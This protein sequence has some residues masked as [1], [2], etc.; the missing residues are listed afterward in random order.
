MSEP[1]LLKYRDVVLRDRIPTDIQDHRRWLTTETAWLDWDAPWE[2][3]EPLANNRYLEKMEKQL[4]QPLPAIRSTLEICHADGAHVGMVNAYYINDNKDKL[5]VGITLRESRYWGKGL[6]TLAFSLWLAYQFKA[7]GRQ[8]IYCETWSGNTRMKKLA[9]KCQ[10]TECKR[11]KDVREVRGQWYDA[12]T[13]VLTPEVFFSL[14]PD[15][16]VELDF[17][18]F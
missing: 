16:E 13:F 14:H 5:A 8:H 3:N 2:G 9:A 17:A 7:T 18:V 4:Q 15:L 11:I 1:L 12:L 10:F 6:G